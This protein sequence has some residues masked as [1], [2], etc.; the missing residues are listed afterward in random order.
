MGTDGRID[1]APGAQAFLSHHLFVKGLAHAVEALELEVPKV[2]GQLQHRR[3]GVGVMGGE[4]GEEDIFA[5][6]DL[7][8]AG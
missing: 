1:P 8:G 3:Q 6:Q 5:G 2:A 7:A 4:Q